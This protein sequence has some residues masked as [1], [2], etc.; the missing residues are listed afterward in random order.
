MTRVI[1]SSVRFETDAPRATRA[2]SA[3]ISSAEE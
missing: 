2:R 1:A 3:S